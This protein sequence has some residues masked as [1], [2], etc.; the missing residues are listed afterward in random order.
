MKLLETF[1][2]SIGG[3][4]DVFPQERTFQRARR[5]VFGLIVSMRLHLTSNAICATG[6]QFVDWTADY[7]VLLAQSLG[8]RIGCSIRSSITCRNCWLPPTLRC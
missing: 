8:P 5:L 6:R 2:R 4:R 7:R 1:D 3:W